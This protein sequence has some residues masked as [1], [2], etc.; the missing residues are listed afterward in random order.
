ML[1][2]HQSCSLDGRCNVKCHCR[3]ASQPTSLKF[4]LDTNNSTGATFGAA[5]FGTQTPFGDNGAD[6]A[7]SQPT[8]F[9]GGGAVL[10]TSQPTGLQFGFVSDTATSQPTSLGGGGAVG[11]QFGGVPN[12]VTSQLTSFGGGEAGDVSNID[13][14]TLPLGTKAS[15]G[16]QFKSGSNDGKSAPFSGLSNQAGGINFGVGVVG[17]QPGS[18]PP[19]SGLGLK[20]K[21]AAP[22][23]TRGTPTQPRVMVETVTSPELPAS[24]EVGKGFAKRVESLG[25]VAAGGT[26]LE[27]VT[28]P[29]S[30]APQEVDEFV[31][32]PG[33][34]ASM[35]RV[36][37]E[38]VTSPS[39]LAAQE[40][41]QGVAEQNNGMGGG[42]VEKVTSSNSPV[43]QEVHKSVGKQ[44]DGMGSGTVETVTSTSSKSP[45]TQEVDADVAEVDD[46]MGKEARSLQPGDRVRVI[47]TGQEGTLIHTN[48]WMQPDGEPK[49]QFR[50]KEL[51]AIN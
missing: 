11:F 16:F 21:A 7:T 51:Q 18:Q 27:T 42:A 38:T 5:P 46:D 22:E 37:V 45:A 15:G 50:L 14:D 6:A 10:A 4:H 49:K 40:I 44:K 9:G 36:T 13:T 33:A 34:G 39:S 3:G 35:G 17:P 29:S 47:A 2:V 31:A 32:E 43:T 12:T 23:P 24:Q 20:I 26:P 41:Y 8:D 48:G 30:L 25:R 28:S 19:D 1:T